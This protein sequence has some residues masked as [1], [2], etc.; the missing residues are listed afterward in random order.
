MSAATSTP[1]IIDLINKKED[2]SK[3]F[4][5]I[6]FFPP[7]T[8]TG[9]KNLYSRMERMKKSINPLFSD[10]T[11]GAGGSTAELTMHLTCTNMEKDGDPKKGV[12]SALETAKANGILN[13][14]AL[15]GDPAAGQDEWKA[16]DGGF[17]C[18]LDLVKYIRENFGSDFGI[19][20]AGYPEGHPNAISLVEDPSTMTEAEEARSSTEGGKVYTCRDDDYKKEMDY[21]KEKV[22]AGADFII[23]QM[24][25]D[26]KVFGTFVKDC[27]TWGINCPIVPGLMCINAFGG[28]AKMTKFCKTRVPA[29]LMAKMVSIKD[30][31]DA[32]KA[33]GVEFGIQMCQ[34]LIEIGVDV[35]HFY[36]LNLEKITY[37]ILTGLGYEVKGSVDESDAKTMTAMGSAW[38][39]VGDKV[40]TSQGEGIVT[41]IA[42]DGSATVEFSGETAAATFKKDDYSKVF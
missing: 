39:R 29:E 24:F 12:H 25:F 16:A 13:I 10:V 28:F 2:G 23:T 4:V 21:L 33:F 41:A 35:L 7:R 20:V 1:K 36:T 42:T 32:V 8:E 37:G 27:K 9:V 5:S 19:S 17:T 6:E 3:P 22:D 14:V 18:A 38:A 15:R 31:P 34:D 26:T 11:W 30:D 40:K